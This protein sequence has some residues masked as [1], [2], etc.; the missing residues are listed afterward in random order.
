M[1]GVWSEDERKLRINI[2]QMIALEIALRNNV[3]FFKGQKPRVCFMIDNLSV[4]HYVNK[5]GGARS[6]QLLK[7][8]E[9]VLLFAESIEC[10]IFAVHGKEE[11][12]VLAYMLS[13][14]EIVLK[15]ELRL[16]NEAF[17]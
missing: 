4:V 5:H 9:R 1:S 14:R 17:E 16:R 2:L 12:N 3:N 10:E 8:A 11:L 15:N 13:R 7:I 6:P